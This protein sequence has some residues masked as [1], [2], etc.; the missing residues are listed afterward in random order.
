MLRYIMTQVQ[1]WTVALSMLVASSMASPARAQW[2]SNTGPA[3]AALGAVVGGDVER[4]LRALVLTGAVRPV[5]WAARPFG[6]DDLSEMF[7]DSSSQA[8]PWQRQLRAALTSRTSLGAVGLASVNS[9]FPWGAND[10][11][12]WQG[13]G[14]TTAI[15]GGATMRLG[16]LSLIAA[17]IA[18]TAQNSAFPLLAPPDY[19]RSPIADPLFPTKVDLPQRMGERSYSKLDAGESS[20]KLRVGGFNLGIATSSAGWGT[21]EAFPAILG[22]NGG[23]FPHIFVGTRG[24]GVHLPML[25]RV[26]GRYIFGV[27]SQTPWSPV[28]G[29]ESYVDAQ[30]S[31]TRRI[32][33]GLSVSLMPDLL[34]NLE[35]G[36]S[37]FY[38][39]P[40][41]AV[42][43]ERWKAW[44]KP[45]EGVLK[46]SFR[47]R[48]GPPGDQNGDIDN[49]LASFFARF[50]FPQRGVE[51]SFE[52]F[53]EDHSWDSRDFAQEAE[54]NGAVMAAIRV[55]THRSPTK[56]AVLT[57]EYFDG[58]IRPIAQA[59]PQGFLY[60]HG[61]LLQGHTQRGQL[62][63]SPVGVGA[64][65]GAK[66]SWESFGASGSTRFT[67]QRLRTRSVGTSDIQGLYRSAQV[68]VGNSHDWIL[69][70]NVSGS[71]RKGDRTL[72]AE[73]GVAW[74][75][76]WQY[77]QARTNLYSRLSWSVF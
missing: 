36:A 42:P 62:L 29:S 31:G 1:H 3:G 32:G 43:S 14:L 37:R 38:H 27:L 8:H 56:L 17:P 22:P 50:V 74:A 68:G 61:T 76:V 24:R 69:D 46:K 63:G 53:R 25:G 18:F 19:A 67:V 23:G 54:N 66:A 45:F 65:S 20:V 33:T 39:S 15:G 70:A 28:Q 41:L 59:R 64:I 6:P 4:Y 73:A 52:L 40:F 75:G 10:G 7:R 9:A 16:P 71:R 34:K 21:G 48:S 13:R 5:A 11:A 57:L 35:V 72:S 58:D 60:V 30:T 77:G 47:D 55:A 2:Q 51:T 44:S 49:Q 26:T 12:L